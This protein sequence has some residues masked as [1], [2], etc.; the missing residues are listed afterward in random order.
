[1]AQIEKKSKRVIQDTGILR[2][3]CGR[4]KEKSVDDLEAAP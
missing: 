1:M 2:I 3:R 4:Q